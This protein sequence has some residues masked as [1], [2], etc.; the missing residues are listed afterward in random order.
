MGQ[1]RE[2]MKKGSHI[3]SL[4]D[5]SSSDRSYT[6][7]SLPFSFCSYVHRHTYMPLLSPLQTI[8]M[9]KC[10]CKVPIVRKLSEP[11]LQSEITVDNTTEV[12]VLW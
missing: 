1:R 11:F 3:I 2:R 12:K 9:N 10:V 7:A 8:R 6:V 5:T 4:N